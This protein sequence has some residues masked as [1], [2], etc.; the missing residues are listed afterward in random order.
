MSRKQ[1]VWVHP[2]K[3]LME[4]GHGEFDRQTEVIST[5]NVFASTQLS[6]FIRAKTDTKNP[7]G[8]SVPEGYLRKYDVDKFVLPTQVRE[9]VFEET[10]DKNVILYEFRHWTNERKIVHGYVMTDVH[11]ELLWWQVTGPT[12]KSEYVIQEC[13]KYIADDWE[14]HF[15]ILTMRGRISK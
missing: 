11:H 8:K 7:I 14:R 9:A 6:L 3:M 15:P 5:G 10:E 4:S 1:K 12:Y 13:I 2:N